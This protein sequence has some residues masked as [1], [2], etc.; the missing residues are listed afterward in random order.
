MKD[1][2]KQI[3]QQIVEL[4]KKAQKDFKNR[5]KCLMQMQ[6]LI[7]DLSLTELLQIDEYIQENK[8]L[9]K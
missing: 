4:E 9:N 2:I 1:E 5:D 3:A 8:L 7:K 6:Q